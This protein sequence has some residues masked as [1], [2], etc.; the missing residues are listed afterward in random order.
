P[1]SAWNPS[2]TLTPPW[3]TT[4]PTR[5]FGATRPQPRHARSRARRI[6]ARSAGV[7]EVDAKTRAPEDMSRLG[8]EIRE[9]GGEALVR[10]SLIAELGDELDEAH[11][12]AGVREQHLARVRQL[13]VDRVGNYPVRVMN[14]GG[15]CI[16]VDAESRRH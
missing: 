8:I 5:G 1:N 14:R 6:A 2:A 16:V 7:S 13:E 15:R 10:T 12:Q 4:A 9:R 11:G 3:R